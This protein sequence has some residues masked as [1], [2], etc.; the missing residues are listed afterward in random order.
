MAKVKYDFNP[1]KL[2]GVQLRGANRKAALDDIKDFLLDKMLLDIGNTKSPVTGSSFQRLSKD[3]KDQKRKVAS[4][5][6]NLELTGAML[7]SLRV[8]NK[9]KGLRVD[10]SNT[11]SNDKADNHNKFSSAAKKTSLPKRQFIPNIKSSSK[12]ERTF[13]PGIIKGINNIIK[14]HENG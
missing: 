14:G 3:Y 11:L 1:F 4:A 8:I 9:G 5:I 13:R 2:S 7:N 6:P 12:S 10:L